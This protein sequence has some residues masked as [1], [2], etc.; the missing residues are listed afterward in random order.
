M[1]CGLL[2]L[3]IERQISPKLLHI[4]FPVKP[5][6]GDSPYDL[7]WDNQRINPVRPIFSRWRVFAAHH[8]WKATIWPRTKI[9]THDLKSWKSA[10]WVYENDINDSREFKFNIY[11]FIFAIAWQTESNRCHVEGKFRA[12]CLERSRVIWRH[13][14]KTP[15]GTWNWRIIYVFR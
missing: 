6:D 8:V 9:F 3:Q 4:W 2:F 11:Y 14:K 13:L 12:E 1:D 5:L 7:Q 15:G 10:W